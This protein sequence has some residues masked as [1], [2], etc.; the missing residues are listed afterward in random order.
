MDWTLKDVSIVIVTYKGDELLKNC[1]DSLQ[2][3]CGDEP[4]IIVVDNSPSEK[5]RFL[6]A[7]YPNTLYVSSPGNPGFAGGNNRALPFCD[8]TFILLLH[9]DT[10]VN[11]RSSIEALVSFLDANPRAGVVQGSMVLPGEGN[12][13]CVCGSLLTPFGF[14][15]ARGVG[16]GDAAD[17]AAPCRCFSALGAFMMFR[18]SLLKKVGG[19]LFRS[20]FWAYYEETDFCHRVWLSGHEVWYVP[21]NPIIHIWGKTASVFS[22]VEI[23]GRYLRNQL[24]SLSAN[25]SPLSR[26]CMLPSLA[27]VIC[28]HAL[29]CLFRRD[30]AMARADL[31]AIASLW[32]ERK[33]IYAARR[34]ARKI[35]KRSDAKIF[36]LV[37]RMP[38]LKYV[39]RS[40]KSIH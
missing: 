1:L 21:T 9:N 28:L 13:S 15:V 17:A 24:F 31:C 29:I 26:I 23:M 4:Q 12:R 27:L 18:R 35:R 6:T 14:M 8:R 22:H 38:S 2:A 37:M 3:S 19:F 5:T 11:D 10:L 34:L 16:E 7:T 36:R 25:L 39:M 33:R 32:R 30:A 40:L 20:H